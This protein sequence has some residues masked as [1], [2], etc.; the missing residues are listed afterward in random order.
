MRKRIGL[1]GLRFDVQIKRLHEYKRQ[2]LNAFRCG[3]LLWTEGWKNKRALSH[4]FPFGA[5]A[6]P[7]Y[8][9]AKGIIKYIN[10]IADLVNNDQK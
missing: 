7:G 4:R 2:L 1:N 5:K 9:R 10:E 6:A 3:Y 8:K